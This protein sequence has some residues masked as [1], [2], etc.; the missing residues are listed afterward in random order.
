[1]DAFTNPMEAKVLTLWL[2]VLPACCLGGRVATQ[3]IGKCG[4]YAVPPVPDSVGVAICVGA[5]A[6]GILSLLRKERVIP[7]ALTG[8]CVGL[9]VALTS[10][11]YDW[12]TRSPY[13]VLR[14]F[15]AAAARNDQQVMMPFFSRDSLRHFSRLPTTNYG[16]DDGVYPRQLKTVAHLFGTGARHTVLLGIKIVGNRAVIDCPVPERWDMFRVAGKMGKVYLVREGKQWKVDVYRYWQEE[17][18]K[19][20]MSTTIPLTE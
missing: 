19:R 3:W 2:L 1:M 12:F 7:L 11:F 13:F 17:Q 5:I 14:Q 16:N 4:A 6:T 15:A 20:G 10:F 8:I 18:L 9:F